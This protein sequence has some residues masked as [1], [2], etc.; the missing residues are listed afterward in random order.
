[1]VS[2]TV[3]EMIPVTRPV[4]MVRPKYVVSNSSLSH[5][6]RFRPHLSCP[7]CGEKIHKKILDC[8]PVAKTTFKTKFLNKIP[9]RCFSSYNA[10][11]MILSFEEVNKQGRDDDRCKGRACWNPEQ[12]WP[13]YALHTGTTRWKKCQ[14]IKNVTEI[15][16]STSS[17]HHSHSEQSTY[18]TPYM[19]SKISHRTR[20]KFCRYSVQL[21]SQT[22]V[23]EQRSD[24]GSRALLAQGPRDSAWQSDSSTSNTKIRACGLG[25]ARGFNWTC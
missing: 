11:A 15:L 14:C 9:F 10:N 23:T 4:F 7:I 1:M 13:S 16:K 22:H 19:A 18:S 25:R 8:H 17:R 21:H 20:T 3:R 5:E 6:G 12:F 24:N 2:H